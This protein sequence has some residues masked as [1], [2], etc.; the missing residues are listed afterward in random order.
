MLDKALR[1]WHKPKL[2]ANYDGGTPSQK[3][4]E[5]RVIIDDYLIADGWSMIIKL[6]KLLELPKQATK[7]L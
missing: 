6:M 5:Q 4:P 1:K 7:R 2:K 3:P